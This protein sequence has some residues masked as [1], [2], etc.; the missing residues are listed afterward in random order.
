VRASGSSRDV[1]SGAPIDIIERQVSEI[2]AAGPFGS[3]AMRIIVCTAPDPNRA[4]IFSDCQASLLQSSDAGPGPNPADAGTPDGAGSDPT[5]GGTADAPTVEPDGG[6]PCGGNPTTHFRISATGGGGIDVCLRAHDGAPTFD[7]PWMQT[8]GSA[9]GLVYPKV[10]MYF[11]VPAAKYDVRIVAAGAVDCSK[12]LYFRDF[13]D[14][15]TLEAGKWWTFIT[16][17]T[18]DKGFVVAVYEDERAAAPGQVGVRF[19]NDGFPPEAVDFGLMSGDTFTSLFTHVDSVFRNGIGMGGAVDA[20]GY[21]QIGAVSD[22]IPTVR[23]PDDAQVLM[24]GPRV[25]L[26][27]G[28]VVSFFAATP[29]PNGPVVY[30]RDLDP[31]VP[32]WSACTTVP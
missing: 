11:D 22:V 1:V 12:N 7:R 2:F 8:H 6:A 5:E 16:S 26:G 21:L 23:R 4:P 3:D 17:G 15:P 31:P 24:K 30:C 14:L 25:D 18:L 28:D 29:Y 13:T 10:S 27:A 32:P 9:E 19:L 20:R